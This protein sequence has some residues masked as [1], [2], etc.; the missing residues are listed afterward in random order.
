MAIATPIKSKDV[1]SIIAETA[2][3]L[4][5]VMGLKPHQHQ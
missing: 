5:E 2:Q 4:V 1:Q 3:F